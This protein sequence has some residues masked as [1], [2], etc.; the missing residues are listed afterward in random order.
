MEPVL[1]VNDA[2]VL[3]P[4]PLRDLQLHLAGVGLVRPRWTNA[5]SAE[6]I[7]RLP[8]DGSR[9]TDNMLYRTSSLQQSGTITYL[10]N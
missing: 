7:A 4:A 5:I 6:A 9:A 10:P 8:K 1:A 3:Y 2:C